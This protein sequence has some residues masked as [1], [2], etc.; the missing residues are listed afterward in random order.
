MLIFLEA[1]P[2]PVT[3]PDDV[4]RI[5]TSPNWLDKLEYLTTLGLASGYAIYLRFQACARAQVPPDVDRFQYTLALSES[6][7]GILR[8]LG[9]LSY[10]AGYGTY[11]SVGRVSQLLPN[12]DVSYRRYKAS[13]VGS[14]LIGT[15]W[16]ARVWDDYFVHED[17]VSTKI[18]Y[19]VQTTLLAEL[20]ERCPSL[21]IVK[22]Y[23]KV[24]FDWLQEIDFN[25]NSN[26]PYPETMAK[27]IFFLELINLD[28]EKL[29]SLERL[30]AVSGHTEN[31][32]RRLLWN[33]ILGGKTHDLAY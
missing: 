10:Q 7:R 16:F 8:T 22:D 2:I 5:L 11:G 21:T 1:L 19:L 27:P 25:E 14:G 31:N 33:D 18:L 28:E 13:I 3:L 26:Y 30:Y 17:I 24:C 4:V 9:T 20:T 32:H 23:Y 15:D 6:E 29:T 12:Y